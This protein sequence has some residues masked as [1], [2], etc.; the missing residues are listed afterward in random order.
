[1]NISRQCRAFLRQLGDHVAAVRAGSAV[2]HVD[3]CPLCASRLRLACR[4]GQQLA[5]PPE[6]PARLRH[7]AF[8]EEVQET[9]VEQAEQSP[10]GRALLPYLE[11]VPVPDSIP[12]PDQCVGQE[13]VEQGLV[14]TTSSPPSWLWTRVRNQVLAERSARRRPIVIALLRSRW[15][16]A[17]AAI[18]LAWLGIELST[19]GTR[20]QPEIVFVTVTELPSL[21]HPAMVLRHG[22]G[23]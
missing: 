13:A 14:E 1:M 18:F 20:P 23:R 21:Q 15:V 3:A 17:A 9:L 2:D 16:A 11:R 12:W 8:L 5:R 22:A 10:L 7:P 6:L 19:H 4:L